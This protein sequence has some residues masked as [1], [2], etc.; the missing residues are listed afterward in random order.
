[1]FRHSTLFCSRSWKTLEEYKEVLCKHGNEIKLFH[2]NNVTKQ[3]MLRD[4]HII[5]PTIFR[6][7]QDVHA[8]IM[9]GQLPQ[10]IFETI[11]KYASK[12]VVETPRKT[13]FDIKEQVNEI[14]TLC[15]YAND[16]IP[17]DRE[18]DKTLK[19][20]LQD[21]DKW[22]PMKGMKYMLTPQDITSEE[23]PME[24]NGQIGYVDSVAYLT[25]TIERLM[26]E[27]QE[28]YNDKRKDKESK[29]MQTKKLAQMQFKI[30]QLS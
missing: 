28:K 11:I 22:D 19:Q 6:S 13:D 21:L 27:N 2:L 3:R 23:S 16:L 1:M 4:G 12:A 30:N 29:Q 25:E 15:Y 17:S 5:K 9:Y 24:N 7:G 14:Q 10:K 18:L 8:H 20:R 26:L